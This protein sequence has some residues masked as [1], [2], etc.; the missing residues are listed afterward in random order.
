MKRKSTTFTIK[1]YLGKNTTNLR[2]SVHVNSDDNFFPF[3][4]G[5]CRVAAGYQTAVSTFGPVAQNYLIITSSSTDIDYILSL[6]R[7]SVYSTIMNVIDVG[8]RARISR[9]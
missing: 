7:G 6:Q 8:V 3:F 1:V 2:A 9:R 5:S 4:I